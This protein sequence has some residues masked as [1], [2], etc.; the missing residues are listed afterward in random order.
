MPSICR[1]TGSSQQNAGGGTCLADR[2]FI[3]QEKA[4]EVL[5]LGI[6][7]IAYDRHGC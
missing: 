1:N 2:S 4:Y 5:S 7:V 6:V 3:R